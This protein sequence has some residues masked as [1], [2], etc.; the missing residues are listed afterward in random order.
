MSVDEG[1][2]AVRSRARHKRDES[3]RFAP[4]R[5]ALDVESVGYGWPRSCPLVL[6]MKSKLVSFVAA[7]LFLSSVAACHHHRRAEGPVQKTKEVVKDVGH[8]T[9]EAAKDVKNDLKK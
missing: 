2:P 9:K 8:D 7:A 1:E 5:A 3:P 6:S 4:A